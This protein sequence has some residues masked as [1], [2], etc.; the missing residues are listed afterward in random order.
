MTPHTCP[1]CAGTMKVSRIGLYGF[2]NDEECFAM[3]G[4]T[5]EEQESWVD[6]QMIDCPPCK[7]TG[8]VWRDGPV[9]NLVVAKL[10]VTDELVVN[11]TMTALDS[12]VTDLA[13]YLAET[14]GVEMGPDPF[15][16]GPVQAYTFTLDTNEFTLSPPSGDY[17]VVMGNPDQPSAP[18]TAPSF[19][20]GDGGPISL[21]GCY[22]RGSLF[23]GGDLEGLSI[24]NNFMEAP[25]E[26]GLKIYGRNPNMHPE[27]KAV[28]DYLDTLPEDMPIM[29][30]TPQSHVELRAA[31]EFHQQCNDFDRD[32]N[33]TEGSILKL[34]R[35]KGYLKHRGDVPP[36]VSKRL[37]GFPITEGEDGVED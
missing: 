27:R 33:W 37:A 11:G 10:T 26:P 25:E 7:G 14:K 22:L 15:G 1:V 23:A 30:L 6:E 9:E 32:S 24:T 13:S 8:I 29:V 12:Q 28:L 16:T 20:A 3:E 21:D 5:E 31:Y 4:M 34:R 35:M 19:R 18:P 2:A 36:E 17:R